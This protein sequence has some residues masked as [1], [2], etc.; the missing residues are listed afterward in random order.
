MKYLHL[1]IFFLFQTVLLEVQENS[2]GQW[3]D[4]LPYNQLIA[5]TESNDFVYAATPY[6]LLSYNKKEAVLNRIS[7]VNGLS[8]FGVSILS[9]NEDYNTLLVTYSNANIDLIKDGK[10]VNLSDIKRKTILG[11]KNINDIYFIDQFAYLSC[12]FGIVV[13]DIEREEIKDTYYIGDNG[14]NVEVF[15]LDVLGDEFFAATENGIYRANINNPNLANYNNWVKLNHLPF[16]NDPYNHIVTFQDYLIVNRLTNVPADQLFALTGYTWIEVISN[17]NYKTSNL[18][19]SNDQLLISFTHAIGIFNSDFSLNRIVNSYGESFETSPQPSAILKST[20]GN[21]YIADQIQGLVISPD[22]HAFQS[23]ILNGPLTTKVFDMSIVGSKVV[24]ASGGR[25]ESFSNVFMQD[26]VFVYSDGSWTNFYKSNTSALDTVYDFVC[27][28]VNPNNS[29]EFAVGTW[30]KGLFTFNENGF[31]DAYNQYNSSLTPNS[32]YSHIMRLGGV[33]YDS[34]NNLWV[35]SAISNALLHKRAPSGEWTAYEFG[36]WSSYDIRDMIADKRDNLW[37]LL[38]GGGAY[39]LFVFD[40]NQ[41]ANQQLIGLNS[42]SGNGNI[43]GTSVLSLAYDLDGEIWIGT[44]EGIGVIYQPENIFYDGDYDAQ[45]IIVERDGYAQ[46]LLESEKVKAIAVDGANRKWVGTERA[47]IFLL[48]AD[49]QEELLNF[50]AE[51]S[52][53]Y[54]NNINSIGITDEGEVFIGTDQGLIVYRGTASK[55]EEP[56]FSDVYSYPNPVRP[57]YFGPIAI[58][59]LTRDAFVKITDISG[60]LVNEI[61]S[62]GGQAIWSGENLKGDR[63]QT[64]IYL[65]FIANIDGSESIVTKIMFIH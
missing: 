43:P 32:T 27:V 14:K 50:T 55:S 62:E 16:P 57:D 35:A 12:G 21:Y 11:N 51:N 52:P 46:Y 26:G 61:R 28:D 2:I 49:G 58:K 37:I 30:G 1:I 29:N 44:D 45:K 33:A 22:L 59:G 63:V 38:R 24:V 40:D 15:D 17:I 31:V 6:S 25:D 23:N 47:G 64:G 20:D 5:I 54:S 7:K 18:N 39:M 4:E 60:R 13:V 9:Y 56:A 41:P 53:L 42:A 36:A 65:V 3:R 10:V 8:D 48:S 34:K 19:V